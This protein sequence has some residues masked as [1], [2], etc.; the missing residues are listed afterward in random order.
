MTN[1]QLK[2]TIINANGRESLNWH[3][4]IGKLEF[5]SNCNILS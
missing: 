1:G 5:Y 3:H 2:A 4:Y